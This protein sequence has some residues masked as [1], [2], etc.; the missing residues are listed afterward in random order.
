[1]IKIMVHLVLR[2]DA[3]L[4]RLADQVEIWRE[5]TAER[6]RLAGLGERMRHD[7]AL[8]ASRIDAESRKPFWRS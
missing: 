5:R 7:L 4:G 1:M 2:V 6:R 3:A 8:S